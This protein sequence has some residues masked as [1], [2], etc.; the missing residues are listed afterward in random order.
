MILMTH[1]HGNMGYKYPIPSYF[2]SFSFFPSL[3]SSL[4]LSPL[5]SL[6]YSHHFRWT[7]GAIFGAAVSR[8]W[9]RCRHPLYY[10]FLCFSVSLS[11]CSL[12]VPI[13]K[14]SC[15]SSFP[16]QKPTRGKGFRRRLAGRYGESFRNIPVGVDLWVTPWCDALALMFSLTGPVER[17]GRLGSFGDMGLVSWGLN[18]GLSASSVVVSATV[19]LWLVWDW[20]FEIDGDRGERLWCYSVWIQNRLC[21]ACVCSWSGVCCVVC[22]C[23]PCRVVRVIPQ[24]LT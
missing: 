18:H 21:G 19:V 5:F 20:E 9:W 24:F 23:V 10:L 8:C 11:L 2:L 15:C 22:V 16:T 3:A 1:A 6:F 4:M 13:K 12:S 17:F 7:A 14:H